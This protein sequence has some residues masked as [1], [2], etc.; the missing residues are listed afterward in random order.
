[1]SSSSTVSHYH[2]HTHVTHHLTHDA[3]TILIS[4]NEGKS[5]SFRRPA[6]LADCISEKMWE[7][8]RDKY[9]EFQKKYHE[10]YNDISD[11]KSS[12]LVWGIM[13]PAALGFGG[14][15]LLGEGI[16]FML[17]CG[18]SLVSIV[19]L[20][21]NHTETVQKYKE[22]SRKYINEFDEFC[23]TEVGKDVMDVRLMD[24]DN[25]DSDLLFHLT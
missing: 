19:Y 23:K 8:I 11:D 6:K 20:A 12:K 4:L 13:I 1:M 21:N 9:D 22:L 14:Y 15:A 18:S 16:A 5:L 7:R 25:F 3:N 10:D 2:Y 17:G 24:A